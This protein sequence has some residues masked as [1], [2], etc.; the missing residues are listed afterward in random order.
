MRFSNVD[1]E[2]LK[3]QAAG[4]A[5]KVDSIDDVG[6]AAVREM[7]AQYLAV[8]HSRA[9]PSITISS[10]DGTAKTLLPRTHILR[11]RREVTLLIRFGLTNKDAL[12]DTT[13][14]K[15]SLK[16]IASQMKATW[17]NTMASVMAWLARDPH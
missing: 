16:D 3:P 14:G 17:G 13:F 10:N 2:V 11:L 12:H 7:V 5:T 9:V 8:K 4:V 6:A 1:S 15:G